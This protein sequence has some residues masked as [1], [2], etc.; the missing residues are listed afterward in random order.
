MTAAEILEELRKLSLPERLGILEAALRLTREE[1]RQADQSANA[2]EEQQY[3]ALASKIVLPKHAV[4]S[5][6]REAS[7]IDSEDFYDSPINPASR[8]SPRTSTSPLETTKSEWQYLF[9]SLFPS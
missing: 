6:L 9:P 3:L 8:I 4:A 1:M 7:V 5:D 2:Q